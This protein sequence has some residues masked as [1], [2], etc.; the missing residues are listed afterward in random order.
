MRSNN[1]TMM[2][3]EF[4]LSNETMSDFFQLKKGEYAKIESVTMYVKDDDFIRNM[5][6]VEVKFKVHEYTNSGTA[7]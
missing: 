3:N 5:V 2:A 4:K 7:I 1:L 6:T